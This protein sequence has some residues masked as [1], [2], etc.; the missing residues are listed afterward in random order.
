MPLYIG[1]LNDDRVF[2]KLAIGWY[3]EKEIDLVK[4]TC[5]EQEFR[6]LI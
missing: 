2:S 1:G 3:K 4:R 5:Y 6:Y